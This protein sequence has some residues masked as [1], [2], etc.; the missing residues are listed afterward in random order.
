MKQWHD[1]LPQ[2]Y[3]HSGLIFSEYLITVVGS[4]RCALADSTG[5]RPQG[6]PCMVS[7]SGRKVCFRYYFLLVRTELIGICSRPENDRSAEN[8]ES[9]LDIKE[10]MT[11]TSGQ[12]KPR[13]LLRK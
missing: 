3:P 13:G 6:M 4:Q 8:N 9:L 11:L 2:F 1:G 7:I 12:H 10:V 5:R